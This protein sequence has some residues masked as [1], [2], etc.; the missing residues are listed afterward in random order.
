V[1]TKTG[2]PGV[3]KPLEPN[4]SND[5]LLWRPE[6]MMYADPKAAQGASA[7]AGR[8]TSQALRAA[9]EGGQPVQPGVHG[10]AGGD[11]A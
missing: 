2:I 1:A 11:Q 6:P 4:Q 9:G 8:T 5:A 3:V 7:R 10:G